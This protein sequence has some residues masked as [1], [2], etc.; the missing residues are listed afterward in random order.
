VAASDRGRSEQTETYRGNDRTNHQRPSRAIARHQSS[1]P[2]G[3]KEH[4]QNQ[5]KDRSPGCR[6]GIS[7]DLNQV[8]GKQEKENSNR[9][10]QEQRKQV[11]AAEAAGLKQHEREHRRS[12]A[13]LEEHES[14]KTCEA[15]NQTPDNQ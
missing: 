1:R 4:E 7:L 12:D 2:A 3:K 13:S 11:R 14:G 10:I 9:G 6:W 8:Q 5:G 15:D